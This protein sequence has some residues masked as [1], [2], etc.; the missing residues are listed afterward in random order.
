MVIIAQRLTL[1]LDA[2]EMKRQN[3]VSEVISELH[4]LKSRL[5]KD[6]GH[7]DKGACSFECSS[8]L[9]GALIKG[10]NTICI[11]DPPLFESLEGYSI[12]ALEKAVL[13][14]QEPNYSSMP[15]SY[16]LCTGETHTRMYAKYAKYAKKLHRC[17][18]SEKIRGII[19]PKNEA[20]V[21]LELN[22]FTNQS[23]A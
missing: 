23:Q 16:S 10:M 12:M 19:D 17:T 13:S 4:D 21:G 3:F 11:L 6:K 1:S 22:A 9:L 7:K 5:Y 15:D 14:I 18:L 20:I 8:I 2:L